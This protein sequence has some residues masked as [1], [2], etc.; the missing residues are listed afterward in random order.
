MTIAAEEVPVSAM[1]RRT[2][3]ALVREAREGIGRAL[4]T[5]DPQERYAES[6]L[7]A[8]RTASA[9][10]AVRAHP[11]PLKS[12]GR[13]GSLSVWTLLARVAPE[14]AEWAECFAAGAA[15]R[16]SAETGRPGAVTQRQSDDLL[17]DAER[18]LG[19]V[20]EALHRPWI[21]SA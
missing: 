11:V 8:L 14:H 21:L 10:L 15:L 6:H 16:A 5:A 4:R 7:A 9:V 20:D 12:R 2:A 3:G 19:I 13:R 17:R 18:F 1:P